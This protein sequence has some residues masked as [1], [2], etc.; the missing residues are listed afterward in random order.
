MAPHTA[1][2]GVPSRRAKPA[3][4][5]ADDVAVVPVE[6]EV[7]W[8]KRVP[9]A[10]MFGMVLGGCCGIAY[11]MMDSWGTK[12]GRAPENFGK[13]MKHMQ[14]QAAIFG[15]VFAA[16]QGTKEAVRT[17]RGTQRSEPYDPTNAAIATALTVLPMALHPVTRK[18]LPHVLF[19]VA[20]DSV[21]DSGIKLY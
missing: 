10:G 21:Q 6:P 12:E 7:P 4:P 13:A 18:T 20:I 2:D 15:G 1:W 9:K 5:L 14:T 17:M 3:P 16:Y 19:L 8:E 11:G